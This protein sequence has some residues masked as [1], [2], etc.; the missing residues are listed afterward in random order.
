MCKRV[1]KVILR[2]SKVSF[3][4]DLLHSQY[5]CT[6]ALSIDSFAGVQSF[7]LYSGRQSPQHLIYR[8][9]MNC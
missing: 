7:S 8:R 9:E 2:P 6:A 4:A 5:C 3:A 1:F